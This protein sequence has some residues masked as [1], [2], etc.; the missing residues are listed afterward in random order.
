MR[1]AKTLCQSYVQAHAILPVAVAL[2]AVA[3]C[4]AVASDTGRP[5]DARTTVTCAGGR[6]F[7]IAMDEQVISIFIDGRRLRLER[8]ASQLGKQYRSGKAALIIDGDFV[9]FVLNEDLAYDDCRIV[10][11]K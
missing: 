10:A 3:A 6:S 1:S 5:D 2:F 11:A 9:A 8:R 4:P 7:D